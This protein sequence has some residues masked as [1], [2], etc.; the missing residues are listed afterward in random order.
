MNSIP[1]GTVKSS[2]TGRTQ[3]HLSKFTH[4]QLSEIFKKIGSKEHTQEVRK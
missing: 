3:E 2:G 1:R 4:Q